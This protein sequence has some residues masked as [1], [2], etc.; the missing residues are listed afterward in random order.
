MKKFNK[1]I[2]L[3]M[4]VLC[5]FPFFLTG[6]IRPSHS[7]SS[8]GSSGGS[9]SGGSSGGS[10]SGSSENPPIEDDYG[11][12]EF[13]DA[14]SGIKTSYVS[15]EDVSNDPKYDEYVFN[16]INNTQQLALDILI[17]LAGEYCEEIKVKE[18]KYYNANQINYNDSDSIKKLIADNTL[19]YN[20]EDSVY[21]KDYYS[22][23]AD[24]KNGNDFVIS[25]DFT[26][27]PDGTITFDAVKYL[28]TFINTNLAQ[29]IQT[30]VEKNGE[31]TVS[32]YV[33]LSPFE[34]F[35]LSYDSQDGFYI[36]SI[37]TNTDK[38]NAFQP[39]NPYSHE[40]KV[41]PNEQN[42]QNWDLVTD[43]VN[44][45][46]SSGVINNLKRVVTCGIL[47]ILAGKDVAVN[48]E[49]MTKLNKEDY[50]TYYNELAKL[51]KDIDH[52]GIN[53]KD[54]DGNVSKE[55]KD[56]VNFILNC[57]IG[58]DNIKEDQAKIYKNVNGKFVKQN[59]GEYDYNSTVRY[60]DANI[61][62]LN[63]M[64]TIINPNYFSNISITTTTND[65][66]TI[67]Y[68][69]KGTESF[70]QIYANLYANSNATNFVTEN[71]LKNIYN[72][73]YE[74]TKQTQLNYLV[75][76]GFCNY[77]NMVE[78]IV[79]SACNAT[80]ANTN[81]NPSQ[82]GVY[83]P[84][85]NVYEYEKTGLYESNIKSNLV[86]PSSFDIDDEN[87]QETEELNYL[88]TGEKEYQSL[89]MFFKDATY[90]DSNNNVH[91]YNKTQFNYMYLQFL[92][93][94]GNNGS[95][96]KMDLY[97]RYH[98]KDKGF[99]IFK[100]GVG[101]GKTLYKLNS[102]DFEI[103]KGSVEELTKNNKEL[104]EIEIDLQTAL[105][106]RLTESGNTCNNFIVLPQPNLSAED[107]FVN[108][109]NNKAN[110]IAQN[111][112][113]RAQKIILPTGEEKIIMAY[114]NLN[115]EYLEILFAV[116]EN[117]KFNYA[118]YLTEF[119]TPEKVS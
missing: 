62:N 88:F 8:G 93:T 29:D 14:V 60:N 105:K 86:A 38:E 54:K 95:N 51:V 7:S 24:Y 25:P 42:E 80:Y 46:S 33:T 85:K 3:F 32:R 48:Q 41:A 30:K 103:E 81:T 75:E 40:Q 77:I 109:Q 53:A 34:Q 98:T 65:D 49:F 23:S 16:A 58:T 72:N 11:Y 21:L 119:L 76:E 104:S 117:C 100:D 20:M 99:S 84:I 87:E 102:Q 89:V 83:R 111:N 113:Y 64:Q 116:P 94:L 1:F 6:C 2:A 56:I 12:I 10:G 79:S 115:E 55:V 31:S 96:I 69:Y 114:D 61:N 17:R 78:F 90:T 52:Y 26:Q 66:E 67:T 73:G 39:S 71:K 74:Q 35:E 5:I 36:F 107:Y 43:E 18:S 22:N 19:H 68:T 110:L 4:L 45:R 101:V 50:T 82:E 92:S 97:L 63:T 44:F 27:N 59:Q 106:N 91:N 15:R 28:T 13:E 108:T 70:D 47:N 9:S 37:T 112:C 57:V 118:F